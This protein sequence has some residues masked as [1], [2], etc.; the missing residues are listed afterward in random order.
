MGIDETS[1][2]RTLG[3]KGAWID[4]RD[5][6]RVKLARL[7]NPRFRRMY[8]AKMRPFRRLE[9]QNKMDPILRTRLIC[10]CLANTVLLDWK[11]FEYKGSP[12][13]YS[14]ENAKNLLTWSLEFR[15]DIAFLA[16]ENKNFKPARTT[17]ATG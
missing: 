4:Y 8:K 1:A 2:G 6:S 14:V 5:G 7:D 15:D 11:G 10:E 3:R 13:P 9:R 17:S 12:L 16:A